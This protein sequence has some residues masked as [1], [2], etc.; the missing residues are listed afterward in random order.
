MDQTFQITITNQQHQG[1]SFYISKEDGQS[2]CLYCDAVLSPELDPVTKIWVTKCHCPVAVEEASLKED[3]ALQAYV[4]EKT[5]A[6]LQK[7]VN[8]N[9]HFGYQGVQK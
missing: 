6:R 7:L 1:S 3:Y 9:V 8:S 2:H 4:L 5:K